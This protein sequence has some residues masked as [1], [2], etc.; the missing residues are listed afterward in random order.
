MMGNEEEQPQ[1]QQVIAHWL[2]QQASAEVVVEHWCQ[3]QAVL[4]AA[5]T[6]ATTTAT[7][8]TTTTTTTTRED[9]DEGFTMPSCNSNTPEEKEERTEEADVMMEAGTLTATPS[10]A[11]DEMDT[12]AEIAPTPPSRTTMETAVAETPIPSTS[13]DYI[14]A[15]AR[16]NSRLAAAA[17]PMLETSPTLSIPGNSA[18]GGGPQPNFTEDV[19]TVPPSLAPGVPALPPASLPQKSLRIRSSTV[20]MT[21]HLRL[22]PRTA[23]SRTTVVNDDPERPPLSIFKDGQLHPDLIFGGYYP[24][25][26]TVEEEEGSKEKG[27]NAIEQAGEGTT[28]TRTVVSIDDPNTVEKHEQQNDEEE[29]PM[30]DTIMD[31][32]MEETPTTPLAVVPEEETN[33]EEQE[34]DHDVDIDPDSVMDIDTTMTTT[35]MRLEGEEKIDDSIGSTAAASMAM[36]RVSTKTLGRGEQK[37]TL[38]DNTA[39]RCG[40]ET[41]TTTASSS[42]TMTT[43]IGRTT[44]HQRIPPPDLGVR[45][46]YYDENENDNDRNNGT[47]TTETGMLYLGE[48]TG[49]HEHGVCKIPGVGAPECTVM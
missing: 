28:N 33:H 12:V 37:H 44:Q 42:T 39:E 8:T 35:A 17:T 46:V 10:T 43:T 20:L 23:D 34:E 26:A 18:S 6:I 2:Q 5:S 36:A 31:T 48:A 14:A 32:I 13:T 47:V 15:T 25:D 19:S 16:T 27:E 45:N 1:Q 40:L 22:D 30:M 29:T 24:P 38:S 3:Q 4:A 9:G 21:G 41:A 7:T 11:I 49:K